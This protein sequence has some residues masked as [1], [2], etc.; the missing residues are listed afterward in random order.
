MPLWLCE[1]SLSLLPSRLTMLPKTE[2]SRSAADER[3][4]PDWL[5]LLV[6]PFAASIVR[7][8]RY[9]SGVSKFPPG[10][11]SGREG[12]PTG[13][14]APRGTPGTSCRSSR[15][16][17]L[18]LRGASRQV[19]AR[20]RATHLLQGRDSLHVTCAFW[21]WLHALET[22]FLF[23]RRRL[24]AFF[25]GCSCPDPLCVPVSAILCLPRFL[26]TLSLVPPVFPPY[27]TKTAPSTPPRCSPPASTTCPATGGPSA[28]I[29]ANVSVYVYVLE[30][31]AITVTQ[32]HYV[33][34]A[35]CHRLVF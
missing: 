22:F 19:S 12:A 26:L 20:F 21:Q 23:I 35:T 5:R 27:C 32:T 18:A 1:L 25:L 6:V 29:P 30:D 15:R 34:L 28:S 11:K 3:K 17:F 2:Y 8:S 16:Y 24:C 9:W 13:K 4:L 14:E 31:L 7:G 10:G 33:P